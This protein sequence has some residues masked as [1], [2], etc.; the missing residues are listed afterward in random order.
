[1]SSTELKN[2]Y[3]T[4]VHEAITLRNQGN[5]SE[6]VF[7]AMVISAS[8]FMIT[9]KMSNDFNSYINDKIEPHFH[10]SLQQVMRFWF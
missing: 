10:N 2:N 6:N 9:Q 4:F 3:Q 8:S 7:T 5:I 1:M